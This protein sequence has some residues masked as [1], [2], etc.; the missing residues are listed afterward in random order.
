MMNEAPLWKKISQKILYYRCWAYWYWCGHVFITA[1]EKAMFLVLVT[2]K[3]PLEIVDK[4]GPAH[5]ALLDEGYQKNYFIASGPRN[6]RTGGV[7]FSQL[8]DRSKLEEFI[9]SDPFYIHGV[10]DYEIIEFTPGKYHPDF[11][12]FIN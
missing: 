8:K 9:K 11:S 12:S 1:G 2:Y 10:A 3:K 4:Y 7:I 6:P 5:R